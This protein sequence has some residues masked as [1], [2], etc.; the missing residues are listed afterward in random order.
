MALELANQEE[1]EL[2][3]VL[4]DV[5]GFLKRQELPNYV[6]KEQLFNELTRIMKKQSVSPDKKAE[7]IYTS[8]ELL[9]FMSKKRNLRR[10]S[11]AL[12]D[13]SSSL[14][15]LLP[16]VIFLL[17]SK[18]PEVQKS[19][20]KLIQQCLNYS[21]DGKTNIVQDTI[22]HLAANGVNHKSDKISLETMKLLP[23]IYEK[24]INVSID[25]LLYTV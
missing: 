7:A 14:D 3:G 1:E 25:Y 18:E 4:N 24:D 12:T 6:S 9:K 16:A 21:E 10:N 22:D 17:P 19:S 13:I 11:H 5:Q 8:G 23:G 20:L 2:L 15:V